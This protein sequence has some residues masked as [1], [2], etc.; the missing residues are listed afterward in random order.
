MLKDDDDGSANRATL[1]EMR[2]TRN[3]LARG[4]IAKEL[5]DMA[6]IAAEAVRVLRLVS[7]ALRNK[8]S[9]EVFMGSA[10]LIWAVSS[11]LAY[12]A[13]RARGLAQELKEE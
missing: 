11:R 2:R 5:G 10:K 9:V 4:T 1:A 12:A 3:T 8:P 6:D 13:R 7:P